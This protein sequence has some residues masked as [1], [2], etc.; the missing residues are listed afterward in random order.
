MFLKVSVV[1]LHILFKKP[2][3]KEVQTAILKNIKKKATK[4]NE[5]FIIYN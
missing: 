3:I 4:N 1:K 5:K 2:Q